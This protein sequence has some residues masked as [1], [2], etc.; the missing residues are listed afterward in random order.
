MK[1]VN[2]R[3]KRVELY[4]SIDELP[5]RRFHKFNKYMLIDSGIGSDLND[6]DTHI[7]K[8]MRFIN[9]DDKYNANTQLENL[10]QS[11][12]MI[13]QENNI[14]HLSFITL[15]K[16]IDGVELIDL[17]DDNIRSL[18]EMF[19][20]KPVTFINKLIT[21]IKKKVDDELELYFP[22]YF[23]D[24]AV[25]EY[26]DKMR[27]RA[28][29]QIDSII[30]NK[31]NTTLIN[32]IEDFLVNLA[33]PKTFS[34]NKSIEISYDKHFEEMCLYLKKETGADADTMNVLQFYNAF[35]YIK[36]LKK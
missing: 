16:S 2:I 3:G 1:T 34:G 25:K 33:K 7:Y 24:T 11:L 27:E 36:K 15:I 31:D 5:I 14:K 30:N 9:M 6:I 28:L 22:G 12:Y 29:L 19:N 26:Y 4:D 32:T 20:E 21:A 10:R 13:L 35:E 23:D 18:S 17:S 8:I